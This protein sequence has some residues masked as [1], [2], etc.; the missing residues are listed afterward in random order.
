M[1]V[2]FVENLKQYMKDCEMTQS[3]LSRA[4]GVSQSAISAWLSA[5]KEPSISSLWLLADCFNCS[6]DELVGRED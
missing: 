2:L 4:I 5:K 3:K 1:R 6:I